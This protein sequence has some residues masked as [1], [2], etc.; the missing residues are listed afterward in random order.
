[1]CPAIRFGRFRRLETACRHGKSWVVLHSQ[2]PFQTASNIFNA[3]FCSRSTIEDL[4]SLSVHQETFIA[5]IEEAQAQI[6]QRRRDYRIQGNLGD[7][8]DYVMTTLEYV[9][10]SAA[11]VLGAQH[12]LDNNFALSAKLITLLE[13]IEMFEWFKIFAEDLDEF[14][15]GLSDWSEF[16]SLFFTNRHLER[17]LLFFGIIVEEADNGQVYVHVPLDSDAEYLLS[18]TAEMT[19]NL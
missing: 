3:Y 2:T 13:N 4:V 11:R 14:Y 10:N 12:G 15:N 6:V 7:L 1:M 16:E 17:W 9:L 19:Q 5:A 8:M 18:V